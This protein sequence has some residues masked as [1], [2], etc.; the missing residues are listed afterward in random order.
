MPSSD[1]DAEKLVLRDPENIAGAIT[2]ATLLAFAGKHLVSWM[3]A[4]DA[5][6]VMPVILFWGFAALL[7]L[8]CLV[9]AVAGGM[10]ARK[11]DGQVTISLSLGP[12]ALWRIRSVVL[13]DLANVAVY[14]HV[15]SFRGNKIRRYTIVYEYAGAQMEL[16]RGLPRQSARLL[17]EFLGSEQS[18]GTR[19]VTWL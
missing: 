7:I 9:R 8:A 14:E 6:D 1:R 15:R 12:I 18:G 3:R 10:V 13:D 16:L 5:S 17:V 4:Q 2:Y 19:A 11:S